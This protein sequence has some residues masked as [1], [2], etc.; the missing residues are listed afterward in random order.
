MV[1]RIVIII[2]VMNIMYSKWSCCKYSLEEVGVVGV[3]TLKITSQQVHIVLKLETKH[4]VTMYTYV[5]L[6]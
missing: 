2:A 4:I 5:Y 3:D 1:V 6:Y